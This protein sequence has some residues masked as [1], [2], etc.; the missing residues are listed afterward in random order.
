MATAKRT[1]GIVAFLLLQR[2][3]T[4]S[5]SVQFPEFE[6]EHTVEDWQRVLRQILTPR[7]LWELNQQLGRTMRG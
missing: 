7:D 1:P 6:R 3:R 5:G 4:G 2:T